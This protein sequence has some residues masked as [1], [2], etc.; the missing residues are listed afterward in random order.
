MTNRNIAKKNQKNYKM[1]VAKLLQGKGFKGFK[2]FYTR[3]VE[4]SLNTNLTPL[5]NA[6]YSHFLGILPLRSDSMLIDFIP[7]AISKIK[8]PL[9]EKVRVFC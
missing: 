6:Q 7:K 2:D 3:S 9:L 1:N 8:C 4:T 5:E